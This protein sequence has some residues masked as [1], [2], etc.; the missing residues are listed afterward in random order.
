MRFVDLKAILALLYCLAST[1]VSTL[2]LPASPCFAEIGADV[3]S[4]YYQALLERGDSNYTNSISSLQQIIK[5]SPQF[6][7]AYFSL[8][9]TFILAEQLRAARSYFEALRTKEPKNPYALYALARLDFAD[10]DLDGALAGLKKTIALAPGYAPAYGYPAGLAEVYRRRRNTDAGLRFFSKMIDKEPTNECAYYGLARVHIARYEWDKAKPL[11]QH[12]IEL[13]QQMTLA[14]HSLIYSYFSTGDYKETIERG[15]QLAEIAENTHDYEMQAYAVMIVGT[16]YIIQGDYRQAL[17]YLNEALLMA[18]AIGAR[19]RETICLNNMANVYALTANFQKALLYFKQSLNLARKSQS[20]VK[21]ARALVNI[22]NV[23]KDEGNHDKGLE[24]YLEALTLARENGIK[25]EVGVTLSNMAE[26]Y[27]GRQDFS[28]ALAFLSEALAIARKTDD[29]YQEGYILRNLGTL[30]QDMGRDASAISHLRQAMDLGKTIGDMQTIWETE[31]GLGS[32]FQKQGRRVDAI[33]HY[34]NAIALYDSVRNTVDIEA[35]RNNFLE[36]KYEAYPSIISLLAATDNVTRAFSFAEKY[37]AKSLLDVVSHGKDIFSNFLA[38]TLQAELKSVLAYFESTHRK[39]SM[40]LRQAPGGDENGLSLDQKLTDLELRKAAVIEQLKQRY[41][42]FYQLNSSVILTPSRIQSDVLSTNQALVEYILGPRGMSVFIITKD[43]LSYTELGLKRNELRQ[44]L[45]DLSPIFDVL[46][47]GSESAEVFNP[48]LADFSVPPAH[49]LYQALFEPIEASLEGIDDLIIVPDD[50]LF[51]LPFEVMISDTSKVQNQY[52]FKNARFLLEKYA[53][54]YAQSASL[55]NPQLERPR[56]AS[57]RILALGNP[58]FDHANVRPMDLAERQ[59][60]VVFNDKR[61]SLRALPRSEDEVHA[62]SS[63]LASSQNMVLTGYDAT[64]ESFKQNA[65]DYK[66]IH[67]ATHFLSEDSQPLYSRIA[68][69]KNKSG[70][71]DGYL[72]THELFNLNLNAEL[73]VL[74]ACNTGIGKLRRGEG[75]V[76]LSRAFLFAGV[77][78]VVVSLWNV[79]D[80]STATIMTSFYQYLQ[81]GEAMNRALRHAKI[82]Y[83]NS[84]SMDGKDPFYWAPFVLMGQSRSISLPLQQTNP[85]WIAN[86]LTAVVMLGLISYVGFFIYRNAIHRS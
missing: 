36:D 20:K 13:N 54:S 58:N 64:E 21:E 19:H 2:V 76:G 68:L 28:K 77:P 71:E 46:T 73:A 30:Y 38:D 72:Q 47:P 11:L 78:S 34:A 16:C 69:T 31:A 43:S 62:I 22:A 37:K 41:P 8:A 79:D 74:S 42:R 82:D 60:D 32:V 50:I 33:R 83:L 25:H 4:A 81:A 17:Q 35:L 26:I 6:S 84:A 67:L 55:L 85:R 57:K 9:E 51:Y 1:S 14:H 39:L 56:N 23:Y 70:N 65:G 44:L 15:F 63:T 52:D 80:A 3:A 66:I 59:A 24:Y 18:Q 5:D 61:G 86:I 7:P 12:A 75:F 27:K 29:K 53:V 40:Q 48:L 49:A 10:N 45:A